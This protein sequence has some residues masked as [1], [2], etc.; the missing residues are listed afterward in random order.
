MN[1][2]IFVLPGQ[3]LLFSCLMQI[4]GK[5][6]KF[7]FVVLLLQTLTASAPANA[8]EEYEAN[9]SYFRLI[10]AT[11]LTCH[12][13][14]SQGAGAI[15]A[16]EGLTEARIKALLHA[17]K[18]DREQGT[19]MNRISKALTDNEIEQVSAVIAQPVR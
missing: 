1:E 13:A 3:S 19:I 15:P 16:L 17:Y 14:D 2:N 5:A 11:C 6:H 12:S 8:G 4:I 9:N 18:T 10:G 7:P